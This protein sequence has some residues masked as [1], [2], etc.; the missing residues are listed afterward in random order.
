[1]IVER[2][3]ERGAVLILRELICCEHLVIVL[4]R[5]RNPL[6]I[7][8]VARAMQNFGARE[9][10][11]VA[12]YEASFREARSAV[13]AGAVLAG[14]AGICKRRGC[15][16][17][18]PAGDWNYGGARARARAAAWLGWMKRRPRC[19]QR[20]PRGRWRCSSVRRSTG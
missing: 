2:K 4:V 17:G 9:L 11:L 6:N 5:T 8:A 1:M 18:L 15:R 10:R 7:G 14:R 13:G 16:C 20:L 19:M 3:S 12:P